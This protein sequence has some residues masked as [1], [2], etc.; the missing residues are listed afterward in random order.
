MLKR[1]LRNI[2]GLFLLLNPGFLWLFTHSSKYSAGVFFFLLGIYFM[3]R[4]KL[5]YCWIIVLLIGFFSFWLGLIYFL[6]VL[7]FI[8]PKKIF[9]LSGLFLLFFG[10]FE[11]R[12]IA[13]EDIFNP[14]QKLKNPIN[15][16]IIQQ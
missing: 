8:N 4:M 10:F 7:F 9:Y 1:D 3:M 5:F 11:Y 14:N 15:K 6:S 16:T 12:F 2:A 13:Y